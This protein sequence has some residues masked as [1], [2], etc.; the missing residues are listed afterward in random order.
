MKLAALLAGLLLSTAAFAQYQPLGA[1]T[2]WT[3]GYVV[4]LEN[5]T[6]RGQVRVGSM[7][8]DSPM[9]IVV[10]TDDNKK[11][12]L[13]GSQI[14]ILAQKIPGY[15]YA[16]GSIPR[17]RQMVIFERVAN[18]RRNNKEML[19]ERLTVPGGRMVLYFDASG[20]KSNREI[21]FGNFTIETLPKDLSY[22]VLK[23]DGSTMVVKR[24]NFDDAHETLF[25]DCAEFV[26]RYPA[27]TRRDWSRFGDMVDAYNQSCFVAIN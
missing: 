1:I 23:T 9:G 21:T 22:I 25:G 19:I 12:N 5:D 10:R 14:K 4:T 3:D 7:V 16:T 20:W 13:K 17:S 2:F 26:K 11:I 24:G 8:N 6:I 27:A 15:A 18:P